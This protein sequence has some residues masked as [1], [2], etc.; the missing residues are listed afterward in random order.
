M[1][2]AGAPWR[3]WLILLTLC[4]L[5]NSVTGQQNYFN[6][7]SGEITE[8]GH[9]FVQHQINLSTPIF[10]NNLT[11][12]YGLGHGFEAGLNVFGI[13][14]LRKEHWHLL[15]NHLANEGPVAPLIL[16]NIQKGIQI[17]Q[18]TIMAGLQ[19]GGHFQHGEKADLGWWHYGV[20]RH[21]WKW[22]K[23]QTSLGYYVGNANYQ[24]IG[25]K[26]GIMLG[27]DCMLH[28]NLHL[29]ADIIGG[30]NSISVAVPG[31]VYSMIN[32]HFFISAGRQI[33][34]NS[35]TNMNAWVFEFTFK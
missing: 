3:R 20:F 5:S 30:N 2:F 35:K 16:G 17:G 7:P 34:M 6:V 27:M 13:D 14:F 21:Q 18:S 15:E 8:K 29:N 4:I 24:G 9:L 11:L 12:D 1:I 22:Q 19:F 32:N 31:L 10:Q 33:P 25:N 28:K 26:A 23:L